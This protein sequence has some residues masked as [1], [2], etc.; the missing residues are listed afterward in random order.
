MRTEKCK[1]CG[2]PIT[3]PGREFC[4]ETCDLEYTLT[5]LKYG[6]DP[7]TNSPIAADKRAVMIKELIN[8]YGPEIVV[9]L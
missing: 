1:D 7:Q 5:L 3:K 6:I 2:K 9:R 8:R 4:D